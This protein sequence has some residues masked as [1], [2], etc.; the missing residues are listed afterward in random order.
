[1]RLASIWRMPALAPPVPPTTVAPTAR[2]SVFALIGFIGACLVVLAL[3]TSKTLV[4]V[5]DAPTFR[6]QIDTIATVFGI[7]NLI[8]IVPIAAVVV[9]G[10][11]GLSATAKGKRAR[12]AAIA[13][14]VIGYVLVV[15]YLNRL[16]VSLL[17]LITFPHAA[18]FVQNSFYWG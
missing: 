16:V 12:W 17:A 5:F 14:V 7:L 6:D 3:L 2:Y 13:A 15:L 11:V 10:H 9:F 8:Q 4:P 18:D 1:M